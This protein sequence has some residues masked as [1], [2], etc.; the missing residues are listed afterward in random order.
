[1]GKPL[2]HQRRGKGSSTYRTP[3]HRFPGTVTYPS[4]VVAGIVEDITNSPGR[5]APIIK[6]N[7]GNKKHIMLAPVG[8]STGAAISFDGEIK[9]G[10]VLTLGKLPE[11][12]EIFNIEVN[13]N[14]GGKLC[15]SAGA[16]ATVVRTGKK[17]CDILLPSK[18]LMTFSASCRAT[19]GRV[20]CDGR[21]DKPFMKAG[22]K[23]HL[24]MSIGKSYPHV[25]GRAM[26]TVDHPFG[27]SNLGR[28]KTVSRNASPGQKVGSISPRSTGK[29]AKS[30]KK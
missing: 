3:S 7:F 15:K 21:K 5:S 14:D 30:S 13:P 11:G 4:N 22:T 24:F 2:R 1:M 18:K 27:G 6:V 16:S 26:N 8:I 9:N 23:H 20:A 17:T 29:K 12:T 10:N 28:L 19:I 25:R